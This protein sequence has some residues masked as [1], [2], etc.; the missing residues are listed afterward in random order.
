MDSTGEKERPRSK[1]IWRN[2][3]F[4]CKIRSFFQMA[5]EELEGLHLDLLE[6][7]RV[8]KDLAE[9]F[10][11][12]EGP[13]KL[14]ECYKVCIL[15]VA[16]FFYF[17]MCSENIHPDPVENNGSTLRNK[18][19]G[20]YHYIFFFDFSD[21]PRCLCKVQTSFGRQRAKETARGPGRTAKE[22]QRG[23]GS[24]KESQPG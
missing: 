10:C 14:E 8:R 18:K 20:L 21:F 13:F 7:D 4:D 11:E 9:F 19:L 1:R 3:D 22:T 6:V 15:L 16:P 5:A 23:H 17:L 12:E 24:Q 2:I